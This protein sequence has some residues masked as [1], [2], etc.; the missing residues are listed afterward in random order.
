[1]LRKKVPKFND[2]NII[3]K[4]NKALSLSAKDFF[5][6]E[7]RVLSLIQREDPPTD[8]IHSSWHICAHK[9]LMFFNS[10]HFSVCLI[11]SVDWLNHA[12]F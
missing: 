5:T 11:I 3:T 2:Q 4:P 9:H 7:E 12:M 6:K 1:M 8:K 10:D